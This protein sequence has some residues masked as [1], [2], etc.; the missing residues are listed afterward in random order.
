MTHSTLVFYFIF[1]TLVE[2]GGCIGYIKARSKAS[3]IA[4]LISGLLLDVAAVLLLMHPE[5]PQIGLILGTVVTV[6]LL[7][8]FAPAFFRTKKFMPAG[9]VFFLSLISLVLSLVALSRI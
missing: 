9:M 3:L 8:R 7:G 2:I 4:G 6:L 5:R 1:A